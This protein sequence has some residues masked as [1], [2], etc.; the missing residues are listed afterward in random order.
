MK[1][2]QTN[3][4]KPNKPKNKNVTRTLIPLFF[5]PSLHQA[6]TSGAIQLTVEMRVFVI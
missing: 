1:Q 4:I 5:F 6:G 3:Q 2:Q